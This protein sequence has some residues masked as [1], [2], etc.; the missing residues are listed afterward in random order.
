MREGVGEKHVKQFG[1]KEAIKG[2]VEVMDLRTHPPKT[3]FFVLKRPIY[4]FSFNTQ[5]IKDFVN[6]ALK[7]T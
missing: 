6:F 4:N 1:L 3:R 2:Q 7:S 5:L